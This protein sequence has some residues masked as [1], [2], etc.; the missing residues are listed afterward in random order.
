[1]SGLVLANLTLPTSVPSYVKCAISTPCSSS[2]RL[3]PL[4]PDSLSL[5]LF[6][7]PKSKDEVPSSGVSW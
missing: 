6:L 1:M 4:S 3:S 2:G 5:L 7:I